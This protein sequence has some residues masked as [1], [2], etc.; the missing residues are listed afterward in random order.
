VL[1]LKGLCWFAVAARG[2]DSGMGAILCK[3]IIRLELL[4]QRELLS[5]RQLQEC[6]FEG[7]IAKSEVTEPDSRFDGN[8]GGEAAAVTGER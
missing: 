3:S 1:I 4:D 5:R 2:D 7:F 8:E 6:E